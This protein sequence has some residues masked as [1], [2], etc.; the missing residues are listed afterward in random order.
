[1][2]DALNNIEEP[3]ERAPSKCL[4]GAELW[5]KMSQRGLLIASYKRLKKDCDRAIPPAAEAVHVP[6]Y[7]APPESPQAKQLCHLHAQLSL[8][9]SCHRQKMSCVYARRA[10][11][12][13]SNSVCPHRLWPA[14]LLCQRG[15][16]PGKNTGAY[17]PIL[18]AIHF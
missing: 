16:S 13:V 5:R 12:V 14:R 8:G 11:L 18:V 3:Q 1:M 2:P 9:Q 10:A 4:N 7:L 15:G 17:W 6:A